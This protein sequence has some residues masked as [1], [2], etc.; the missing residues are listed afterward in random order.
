MA[1]RDKGEYDLTIAGQPYRFKMGT[2]ATIELQ[3]HFSDTEAAARLHAESEVRRLR[4]AL[5]AYG[6]HKNGCSGKP[7]GCGLSIATLPRPMQS[8]APIEGIL[9]HVFSGRLKYIAAF[10]W[11]GLKTFQPETTLDAAM[12][13]LDDASPEE[14]Q[15]LLVS[16]GLT[17][18][19]APEDAK[20]LSAEGGTKR[21]RKARTTVGVGETSTS[22]RVRSV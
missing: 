19:P 14:V 1:N 17:M 15:Q 3:E 5:S 16:L 18:Q 9:A 13:L 8:I 10:V 11:A 4:E 7:C 20:E 2:A 6:Q 12:S 21:P 22:K